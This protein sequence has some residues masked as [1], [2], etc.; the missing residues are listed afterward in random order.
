MKMNEK[1]LKNSWE[2]LY[3]ISSMAKI[4]VSGILKKNWSDIEV[5]KGYSTVG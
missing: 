3:Y 5:L 2:N 4:S 1:S